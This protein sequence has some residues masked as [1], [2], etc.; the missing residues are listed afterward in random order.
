M[1]TYNI[2]LCPKCGHF[3]Y[4]PEKTERKALPKLHCRAGKKEEDLALGR[5][6]VLS[7]PPP[8]CQDFRLEARRAR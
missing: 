8:P 7:N 6:D 3:V 4:R 2:F 5:G 1:R